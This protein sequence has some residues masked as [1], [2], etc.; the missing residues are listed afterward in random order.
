MCALVV[1]T[2]T[3]SL[4]GESVMGTKIGSPKIVGGVRSGYMV[5]SLKIRLNI[6]GSAAKNLT[7]IVI[8]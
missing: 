4:E 2:T 3:G 8:N 7:D 1:H 6:Y 5:F